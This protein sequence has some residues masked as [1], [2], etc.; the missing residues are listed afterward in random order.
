MSND[1]VMR[2]M[3]VSES[4]VSAIVDAPFEAVDIADWVLNLPDAE[5]QRCAPGQHFAAGRTVTDDGLPMSI[6]VEEVG[7]LVI[8]HYVAEVH[9]PSHCRMV[10]LSDVQMPGGW[11]KAQVIWDL[12]LEP[13][14]DARCRFINAVTVHPTQGFLD[15]LAEGGV[16]FEA[17]A[18]QQH[19]A[20]V[21]HNQLETP[22][23][24]ASIGRKAPASK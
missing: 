3:L 22:L 5:Y 21:A 18:A 8:Q 16:R 11:T 13:I 19:A 4:E 20:I 17:V 7:G 14:D 24:A 9:E 12:R 23:Y 15:F 6:N 2:D 1:R 10:S